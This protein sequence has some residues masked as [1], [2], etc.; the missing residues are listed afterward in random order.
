MG[1]VQKMDGMYSEL[2]TSKCRSNSDQEEIVTK[3]MD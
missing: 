3:S 1:I 2:S